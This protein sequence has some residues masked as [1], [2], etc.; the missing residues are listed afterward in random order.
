MD[1]LIE[2]LEKAVNDIC[3]LGDDLQEASKAASLYQPIAHLYI[4]DLIAT[5]A[6]LKIKTKALLANLK[7]MK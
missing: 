6:A 3:F 7:E 5:Q 2:S 1:K 4:V